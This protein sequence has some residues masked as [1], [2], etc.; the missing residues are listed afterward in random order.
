MSR[1]SFLI[2]TIAG[3]LTA[4][5]IMNWYLDMQYSNEGSFDIIT[6]AFVE[7]FI[8]TVFFEYA[9]ARD[10]KANEDK[11]EKQLNQI[12]SAVREEHKKILSAMHMQQQRSAYMEDFKKSNIDGFY[13]SDKDALAEYED[14]KRK[15]RGEL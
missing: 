3:A 1:I 14:F 11:T 9:S 5:F 8:L 6:G 2:L 10:R 15:I 7:V 13:A 12:I 4:I